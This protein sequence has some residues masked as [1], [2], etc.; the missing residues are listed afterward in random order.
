MNYVLN[1]ERFPL[2]LFHGGDAVRAYDFLGAHDFWRDGVQGTMF[3]VWAP[4]ALTVSVVGDFNGWD[5]MANYMYKISEGGVW[6]CWIPNLGE[7]A[8]YKYCVE[9]PWFEKILKSDPFA[10]H[11][12]TRPDN[13]SIIYNYNKYEWHDEE[14]YKYKME[15][16]HFENPVN[17]YEVHAG[18]WRKYADGNTFSYDKL[19][20]ELIPYVKEMGYTHIEFMPMTEYPFDGSWGYQVTGY[21]APTSRYGSPDMFMHFI[22]QC[23][24]AGIGVILDWVPAHFPK[25]AHGLGRFDGI[26]CYEYEDSRKGEHK[27]WGTYVF[28]YA[29]Y[30]VI[31]FLVSSAMFWLDKYHVD[32]IRVDAVASMLYLDYNRRDGE[33]VA[34]RYGGHEHLEAVEFIQRLNTAVHLHHPTVMMI[35]EESTS[36]P[37]VSRPVSD[38]GLGFDYKWNMG[39]MN[40]MLSYMS[41]DPLWRPYHHNSITF[42]FLYAFSENFLLPISHDEVVYGKGSLINKMPGDYDMKFAGVR[43]F[44][45][46]M[47]AHPG[48]KLTFMGAEIGQFDEWNCTEE[49]QW[50]LLGFEKHKKLNDF[51]RA[52]NE[53]Y[54]ANPCMHQVDFT[55]EGFNWIHHDDYQQSVIAFRRIDKEGNNI[56]VVCN[57]QPMYRE[58]YF[59][60]VPEYGTYKEIFNSDDVAFG[61]TGITNG[62]E[63]KSDGE[64]MHG[65]EQSIRLNL[66]PMS[67]LY[68]K[69]DH[70]DK[71]PKE[72]EE[73]AAVAR[74]KEAAKKAAETRAKKKAEKAA[75]KE[76]EEKAKKAAKEAEE[77]AKKAA[78][79]AAEKA[80]KAEK[81]AEKAEKA[82]KDAAE[83]AKKAVKEK[84]EKVEKKA[85]AV[86]KTVKEKAEKK[87]AAKKAPAKKAEKKE[88]K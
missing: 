27:E 80:E 85:A 61:G 33:W 4:N 76:A 68:L 34:N 35:A 58:N 62:T 42:S 38:G 16:N 13:A 2:D 46:Y 64:P 39:W 6:E 78:K 65:F 53:F 17:I 30:E 84:A 73:E 48:K 29:R 20:E 77:K 25:D 3:R 45:S 23:H 15:H 43:V 11:T 18:S 63:I 59:I 44:M 14:W 52:L 75:A 57:F 69:L 72:L 26:H 47:M 71:T 54:K 51:F 8:I 56:I 66:P 9:T 1:D 81:E 55:W 36:W 49:L 19:A 28:D 7:T 86:K 74:R 40:D 41:L 50:G 22:D 88:E 70:K 83:K 67:A 60:G 87:T 5:Q 21:Y 79:E 31:S 12:Q 37:M 24:A 32:G 10:F 82:A